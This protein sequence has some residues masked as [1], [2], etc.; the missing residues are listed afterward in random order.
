[1]YHRVFANNTAPI[2]EQFTNLFCVLLSALRT[3]LFCRRSSITISESLADYFIMMSNVYTSIGLRTGIK[4]HVENGGADDDDT[5]TIRS[6]NADVGFIDH[7]LSALRDDRHRRREA[8]LSLFFPCHR[9][10]R[11]LA[12]V[13]TC[14]AHRDANR[15]S[16]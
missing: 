9:L 8:S 15:D 7:V 11:L 1:M 5:L 6:R 10:C 13:W 4:W 2:R 14:M 3:S 12:F 16:L